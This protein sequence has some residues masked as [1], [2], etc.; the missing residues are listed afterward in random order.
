MAR[1]KINAKDYVGNPMGFFS[2]KKR[3]AQAGVETTPIVP[4]PVDNTPVAPVT[5]KPITRDD[6]KQQRMKNKLHKLQQ[7]DILNQYVREDRVADKLADNR[8][9]TDKLN[10]TIG[11]VGN[12]VG[13]ISGMMNPVKG[14]VGDAIGISN[15]LQGRDINVAPESNVAPGMYT[16]KSTTPVQNTYNPPNT[17][18]VQN[19]KPV[20]SNQFRGSTII[21]KKGGKK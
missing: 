16:T 14:I 9:F 2:D 10:Q 21:R 12:V 18:P 19:T 20:T 6:F 3:E 17:S 1:K 8:T 7:K 15:Q 11:T 4:A 5:P 13:G